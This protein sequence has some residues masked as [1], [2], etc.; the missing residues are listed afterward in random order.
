VTS[1]NWQAPGGWGSPGSSPWADPATPTE[2]GAPYT[3]PPPTLQPHPAPPAYGYPGPQWAAPQWGPTAPYGYPLPPRPPQ[4]PGQLITA[5]VLAFTQAV[6]VLIASLYL[7][8][9]ASMADLLAA[10]AGAGWSA[11]EVQALVTEG[12]VLAIVQLVSA[13]LLVGAGAWALSRRARGAWTLL[14]AALALQVVL[15][16]YWAVRLLAEVGGA[17]ANGA[18]LSLTLLFAAAPLVGLGMLLVGPGKRWFG[19]TPQ[20]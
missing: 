3:G 15:A 6:L 2:P 5:A 11:A 20:A 10:E 4:R 7:W 9:F 14:V 12:T 18:I 13:V 8:F 17:D 19:G 1:G 16:L